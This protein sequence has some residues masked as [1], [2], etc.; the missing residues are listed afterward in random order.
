MNGIVCHFVGAFP[1]FHPYR[2]HN[3]CP[4]GQAKVHQAAH[5]QQILVLFHAV[6]GLG[7]DQI[8]QKGIE[9]DAKNKD[10]H[11]HTGVHKTNWI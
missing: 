9:N 10:K 11:V 6:H 5:H 7:A 8:D 1:S 3:E 4:T 2:L